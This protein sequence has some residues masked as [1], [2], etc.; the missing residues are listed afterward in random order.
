MGDV[1]GAF[2]AA[3]DASVKGLRLYARPLRTTEAVGNF[4]AGGF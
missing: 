4:R 1:K 3:L 2:Q